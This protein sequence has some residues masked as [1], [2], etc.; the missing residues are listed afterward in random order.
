MG[1]CCSA[2]T[3][4]LNWVHMEFGH[5]II[6]INTPRP[7]SRVRLALAALAA[8]ACAPAVFAEDASGTAHA[9]STPDAMAAFTRGGPIMWA[10]A[11]ILLAGIAVGIAQL[12]F[13]SRHNHTPQDF[14][15]DVVHLADTK[16]MDAGI[17]LCKE[18]R[19]SLARVLQAAL[20]R[21]GA[22]LSQLEAA[23]RNETALAKYVL[24]K[25]TRLLGWL[26]ALSP[27]LGLLGLVSNLTKQVDLERALDSDISMRALFAGLNDGVI[28]FT[29]SLIVTLV[30]LG[31]CF[32]ARALA[33][34][35]AH[36]IEVKA[37]DA[38]VTLDRKARQ[39]IRLIEDI[40]EKIKTESM[41]KVPDLSADFEEAPHAQESAIKTAVTTH[42][43]GAVHPQ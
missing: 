41:I 12:L 30:A 10:L 36:D 2:L 15:K 27:I 37:I 29:F 34:D 11:S 21:H 13:L 38:V 9:L 23:V 40:E 6:N 24:L 19:S 4:Y 20:I 25:H 35:L 7:A 39:S 8:V 16:G 28:C 32:I 14:E 5:S 43:G 22:P 31:L 33:F 1:A 18:K 42:A 3:V 26:A 17:A